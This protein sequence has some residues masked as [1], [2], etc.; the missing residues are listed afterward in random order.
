MLLASAEME[1]LMFHTGVLRE[2][3]G[4]IQDS[5][6]LIGVL[7][8]KHG[9]PGSSRGICFWSRALGFGG[10]GIS[11]DDVNVPEV[12][13]RENDAPGTYLLCGL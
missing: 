7:R 6:L 1:Q 4:G 11:V 12:R 5:A 2:R 10:S 3:F 8:D 9:C 13:P